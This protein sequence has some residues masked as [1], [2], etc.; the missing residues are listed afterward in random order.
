MKSNGPVLT[1]RPA[2]V[3]GDLP[4]VAVRVDED[5]RVATPDGG[6][7]GTTDGGARCLRVGEDQVDFRWRGDVVG[8]RDAPDAPAVTGA[9]WKA[10]AATE[11]VV[12]LTYLVAIGCEGDRD[13]R[14]DRW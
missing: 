12:V 4:R 8:E 5:A 11:V 7:S 9:R 3:V 2:R 13:S 10:S 1:Q 6:R 14:S